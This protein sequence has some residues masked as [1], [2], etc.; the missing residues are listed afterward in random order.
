MGAFKDSGV[1]VIDGDEYFWKVRHWVGA[2]GAKG[3]NG[4]SL[5]VSVDPGRRRELIVE[6]PYTEFGAARPKSSMQFDA[7]LKGCIEAALAEGWRPYSRGRPWIHEA[8][9]PVPPA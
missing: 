4:L 7:R 1:I 8:D 9:D 3:Q 5:S 6:F 2:P